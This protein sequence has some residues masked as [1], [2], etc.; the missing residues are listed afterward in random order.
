MTVTPIEYEPGRYLVDSETEPI[1]WLV[2]LFPGYDMPQCG[3]AIEHHRTPK[4]W[5]CHHVTAVHAFLR[6]CPP[7]PP[8]AVSE[9]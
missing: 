1:P 2:D 4:Y 9:A 3:C 7:A 6:T 8:V 5:R